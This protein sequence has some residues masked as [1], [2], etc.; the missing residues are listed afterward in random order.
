MRPRQR[1]RRKARRR[2]VLVV[3]L[4]I[5]AVL[6]WLVIIPY[7]K[8]IMPGDDRADLRGHLGLTGAEDTA[9]MLGD[10]FSSSKAITRG[11]TVYWD[12][13]SIVSN[14][15]DLFWMNI[16]DG[17]LLFTTADE[18][19]RANADE[20]FYTRHAEAAPASGV[21]PEAINT[22]V[23]VFFIEN[24]KGYISLN[25]ALQFS[26]F[27]YELFKDPYRVQIYADDAEYESTTILKNTHLRTDMDIKSEIL[28]DL[29]EDD[30][31]YLLEETDGWSKVRTNDALIGYVQN[32][33][34][35]NKSFVSVVSIEDDFVLPPYTSLTEDRKLCIAWHQ[36]SVADANAYLSNVIEK[37]WSLDVVSPTWYKVADGSGAIN[38]IAWK[39]YV[40]E[41][42]S[43]GLKVWPLVDD[44][45]DGLD[46]TRLLMSTDSRNRF[47][48]Y[49]I[50]QAR[51]LG[52][53]GINLDFEVVPEEAAKGFEQ[54]LRE[55]SVACRAHGLVF[56]VDNYPPREW[57][58]HYNRKLQ[59]QVADYVIIMGYD[60]HWGTSSG[61]GSVA[62][63]PF[64]VDA[65]EQTIAVVPANKVINAVPFY[66][67]LWATNQ[68]DESLRISATP[69][70]AW[71]D[72]W[73]A[74][75]EIEPVWDEVLGQNFAEYTRD[76]ILYQMWLEDMD[77]MQTRID[78]MN[79]FGLGGVAGWRL[80]LEKPEVWNI[81]GAYT[82]G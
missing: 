29:N 6:I 3:L 72:R 71:Q 7:V 56:S 76:N 36:V 8:G 52:F 25:F 63:L 40:N 73:L 54:L 26:N 49:L 27:S 50:S 70:M 75:H 2:I 59:G 31:V 68:V 46:R 43:R 53:D 79:R 9:V 17:I 11:G 64:V 65:I 28:S 45:T 38:S 21:A 1:S 67:R 48:S 55:L 80:G 77:S 69:G 60:E 66:S 10:S 81:L 33:R 47:V 39:S 51:D 22:D 58:E 57:T 14:F 32:K 35:A 78:A 74:E 42:H 5:L 4:I 19:V 12:Y 13:D 18:V 37:A 34:I 20:L 23:P 15:T 44:F 30:T 82:R 61:A 41:A 16:E 62:S 24:G